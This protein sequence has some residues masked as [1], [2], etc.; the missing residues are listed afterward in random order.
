MLVPLMHSQR[1]MVLAQVDHFGLMLLDGGPSGTVA[2]ELA[3][4][5]SGFAK[6]VYSKLM[7]IA[8]M[9]KI[10]VAD[11]KY[12]RTHVVS[13][14]LGRIDI[15][16]NGAVPGRQCSPPTNEKIGAPTGPAAC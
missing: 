9:S 5:I 16:F 7:P 12:I 3:Y 1:A 15:F 2:A 13:R 11:A 14:N 6:P 10:T 8:L 4:E